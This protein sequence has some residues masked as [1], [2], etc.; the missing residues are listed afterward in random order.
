MK[1]R[2]ASRFPTRTTAE[3]SRSQATTRLAIADATKPIGER[4]DAIEKSLDEPER[5]PALGGGRTN[6][7]VDALAGRW[8]K[9]R[10]FN[11]QRTMLE[12]AE[13]DPAPEAEVRE[14]MTN[15]TE[16]KRATRTSGMAAVSRRS[17]AGPDLGPV[18]LMP[19][20]LTQLLLALQSGQVLGVRGT[21]IGPHACGPVVQAVAE[22]VEPSG[23]AF[24]G[25]V[26]P[27]LAG[28]VPNDGHLLHQMQPVDLQ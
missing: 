23:V 24:V 5:K 26:Q 3:P 7:D 15:I 12:I 27:V 18:R 16:W 11:D 4:L 8:L 17:V 13:R 20:E 1:S 28:E 19:L 9:A 21:G 10:A 25:A 6:E 22:D 14:L 2:R